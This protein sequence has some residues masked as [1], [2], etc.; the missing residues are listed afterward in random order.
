MARRS[1]TYH[2]SFVRNDVK[3]RRF[4][5]LNLIAGVFTLLLAVVLLLSYISQWVDPS[6]GG[7]AFAYLP[8]VMP[9]LYLLNL[10]ML[11]FWIVRWHRMVFIPILIGLIGF[12]GVSLF[13]N[14]K[15]MREYES[16]LKGKRLVKLMTYNAMG[17]NTRENNRLVSAMDDIA[18]AVDS[19]HPDILCIQEFQSTAA[20]SRKRFMNMIPWLKHYKVSY[21][22]D[23]KNDHGWGQAIFSRYPIVS[24][25]NID[26]KGLPNSALWCDI[27]VR[28]DT[29]RVFNLHLQSTSITADETQYINNMAFVRD[30]TREEKFRNMYHKLGMNFSIRAEQA[31]QIREAVDASPHRV[32][33]CGDFNDTPMSYTYHTI[34]NK[35][36]DSYQEVG[37]GPSYT[38]KS[39]FNLLRIDY[40]LYSDG[41]TAHEYV[42]PYFESSDH[43][44]IV[45]T[46]EL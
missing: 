40:V 46:F 37:Y 38:Y 1:D 42:S 41:I 22:I 43:K 30:T 32:V 15:F 5:L 34:A 19:M 36:N 16:T 17:M 26:F 18:Q 28:H 33:V 7:L 35:L 14:P 4:S 29:L 8:L 21:K 20:A 31:R 11:L 13:Y 23:T 12:G 10:V 24:S 45:V 9:V 44:P 25:G 39:F 27:V 3:K 2:T 6:K